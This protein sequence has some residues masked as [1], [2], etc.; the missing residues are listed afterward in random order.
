MTEIKGKLDREIVSLLESLGFTN[1]EI[2]AYTSLLSN[3]ISDARTI[4]ES[5]GVPSSKIYSIMN[6]FKFLGLIEVQNSK[7][8]KFKALDP[9][10]GLKKL[11]HYKEQEIVKLKEELPFVETQLNSIYSKNIS[12]EK[13]FFNLEF[14]M[15][16]FVHKHLMKLT[17]SRKETCSYLELNCLK[18]VKL[19]G[20]DVRAKLK[21]HFAKYD[22]QDRWIIGTF[23]RPFLRSFVNASQ[24]DAE[25]IRVT[26]E[27][28]A[29]FSV[30]DDRSVVMVIDN[31]LTKEGR[32]ASVYV[33]DKNLAKEMREGFEHLWRNAKPI[34]KFI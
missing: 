4:C 9:A 14:G 1:Y 18:S 21:H 19:H 34:T 29:P 17:E 24:V 20:I 27:I 5:S 15:K 25:K 28:H 23:N 16:N 10:M 26:K 32:V 30:I 2:K 8:A 22:I 7:P 3:G 12:D 31:P 11:L 6:K 33:M 13:T